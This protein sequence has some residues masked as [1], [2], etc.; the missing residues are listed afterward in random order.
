MQTACQGYKKEKKNEASLLHWI[1][2]DDHQNTNKLRE[3][4]VVKRNKSNMQE[5]RLHWY[6]HMM[7]KE[8][9][10]LFKLVEPRE[11]GN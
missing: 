2:V 11:E 3:K 5:E 9:P 10:K 8:G 4:P 6:E 1:Y 7:H